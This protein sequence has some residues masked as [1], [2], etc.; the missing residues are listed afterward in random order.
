MNA[1][2]EFVK[3]DSSDVITTSAIYLW[4]LR[5][6]FSKYIGKVIEDMNG[7]GRPD[8]LFATDGNDNNGYNIK[9][10]GAQIA[11]ISNV[12]GRDVTRI[13][14]RLERLGQDD[15][16][17]SKYSY[18]FDGEGASLEGVAEWINKFLLSGQQ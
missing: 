2:V 3:F 11:D 10:T 12:G 9:V 18:N 6:N 5:D 14:V 13:I 4:G 15:P 17:D 1:N 7:D 16:T 8:M